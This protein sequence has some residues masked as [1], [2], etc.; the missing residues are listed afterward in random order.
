MLI[1]KTCLSTRNNLLE[2]L[3]NGVDVMLQNATPETKIDA[4]KYRYYKKILLNVW[5]PKGPPS[6]RRGRKNHNAE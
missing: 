5:W 2:S 6:D 3:T 1:S 4:I